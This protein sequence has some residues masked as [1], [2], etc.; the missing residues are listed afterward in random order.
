MTRTGGKLADAAGVDLILVGDTA[1]MVV[2]GHESSTVP[3]TL[4]EMVFMTRAVTRGARRPLVVGDMPFGS[5]QVVRRGGR[6]QRDPLR[7]GGGRR[8][9]QTRGRRPVADARALDR[10][11]GHP[12]D[13]PHRP[14]AAVRDD[15]GRLQDA[16]AERRGRAAPVRG[17]ARPGGGRVL[18][19]RARGGP[20]RRR[21]RT[22]RRRCRSRRSASAPAP[23]ATGRCS[24]GTTSSASTGAHAA[25]RA[26]LAH[27]GGEISRALGA[28][29]ERRTLARLP[30][31]EHTYSMSADERRQF[32]ALVGNK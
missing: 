31:E 11:R 8:R 1:A 15:A 21:R 7:Q 25:L 12:G 20:R 2:L 28:S 32:E 5:Y 23:A 29:R 16:G 30:G 13:G 3:V 14:D 10:R 17:R 24:C 22:S 18:R 19:A 4:D 27:L 26:T 9:H 6:P